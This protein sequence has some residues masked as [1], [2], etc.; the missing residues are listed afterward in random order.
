MTEPLT[1]ADVLSAVMLFVAGLVF[2]L[3]G[4]S[5][6]SDSLSKLAGGKMEKTLLKRNR[7]ALS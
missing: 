4:M 2:F 1:S 7:Y 3:F 6:M 5:I